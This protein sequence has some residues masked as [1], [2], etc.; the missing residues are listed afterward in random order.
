[1]CLTFEPQI[2]PLI[3]HLQQRH[4]R[5]FTVHVSALLS[6][7][8]TACVLLEST[9]LFNLRPWRPPAGRQA[10]SAGSPSSP[11]SRKDPH[12][13]MLF[14]RSARDILLPW[15]DDPYRLQGDS[16]GGPMLLERDI[17]GVP[18]EIGAT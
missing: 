12:R 10:D 2:S 3:T 1:M 7:C 18:L 15:G 13:I 5:S 9:A 16:L 17:L 14:G 8:Q 11:G 4:Q 6:L